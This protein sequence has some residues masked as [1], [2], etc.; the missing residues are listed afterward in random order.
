[1]VMAVVVGWVVI[2]SG[3][4]GAGRWLVGT[5][6]RRVSGRLGVGLQARRR[7]GVS[8]LLRRLLLTA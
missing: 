5:W 6:R 7:R 2:G 3:F 1:V 4:G 8:G